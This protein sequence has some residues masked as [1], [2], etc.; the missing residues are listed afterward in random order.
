MIPKI[1]IF[2]CFITSFFVTNIFKMDEGAQA[3]NEA[4]EEKLH[5]KVENTLKWQF[6]ISTVILL[7]LLYL[8]TFLVLNPTLHLM[9]VLLAP[10]FT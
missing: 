5:A 10:P 3:G 9:T 2:A 4:E 7:G 6:I 8:R 1:G